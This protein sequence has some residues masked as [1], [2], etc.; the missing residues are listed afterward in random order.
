MGA[1]SDAPGRTRYGEIIETSTVRVWVESDRLHELPALGSVVSI[2][3]PS[4]APIYAIVSFGQTAGIDA[5]RRAIR[6]GSEDVRDD[7][8]YRRHPELTQILRTTF[9]VLPVA[10]R[11]ADRIMHT[12]P[13]LPP[14]LHYSVAPVETADLCALTDDPRY[15]T[16]LTSTDGEVPADQLIIAHLQW[17]ADTRPDGEAW[18]QRA[19]SEVARLLKSDYD[20]LLPI[21]EAIDPGV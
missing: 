13:P 3:T 2:S 1:S 14:P 5:T 17:V 10:Y 15:L 12:L 6:R 18:L 20:R 16:V 9:E 19:A 11:R 21:L 4:G 7:E 8:I